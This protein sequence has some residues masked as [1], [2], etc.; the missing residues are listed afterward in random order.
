MMHLQRHRKDKIHGMLTETY[1]GEN[2]WYVN[3]DIE[4]TKYMVC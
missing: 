4:K 3:R 1:K 2:T